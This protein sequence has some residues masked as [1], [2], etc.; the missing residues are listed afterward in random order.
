VA[1]HRYTA[2]PARRRPVRQAMPVAARLI[3][4]R[5]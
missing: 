5:Y 2:H 3:A 4:G 1:N